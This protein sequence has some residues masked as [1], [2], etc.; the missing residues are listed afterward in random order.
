MTERRSSYVA[1]LIPGLLFYGL[2]VALPFFASVGI[3]FTDWTGLGPMEFVGLANFRRAVS[4]ARFWNALINNLYFIIS[5]SL[6]P[7]AIS[8]V[9]ATT[10]VQVVAK[11]ISIGAA[12]VFRAGFYLPQVISIVISALAWRWLLHPSY[13]AV[14]VALEAIGLEALT[15]NWLGHPDYALLSIMVVM[16]WWNIG[17]SLVIFMAAL[18]RINP[19]LFET[20]KMDGAGFGTV[21]RKI[22]VPQILAELNVV[23]LTTTIHALKVF[24]PVYAMTQGGPGNA[25]DVATYFV[26][27]NFFEQT[28]VGYGSA[29]A[30]LLTLVVMAIATVYVTI[31]IRKEREVAGD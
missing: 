17:Y 11:R 14:N 26:Y 8:L 21:L 4:D 27:K 10:L 18:Q 5:L 6:I 28:R 16:V 25:T 23:I 15:R 31:E 13:G 2:I 24:G 9:L 22:I 20:A 19:E 1:F 7:A 3:S 30:T 12:N 29:V